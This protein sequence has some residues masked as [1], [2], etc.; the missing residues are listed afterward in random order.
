MSFTWKDT[1]ATISM[2][3]A[4]TLAI[5]L[6]AGAFESIESRWAL[7]TFALLVLGG[8]TGLITGT[9]KMMERTWSIILLYVVTV[10]ALTITVVNAFLNSQLWFMAMVIAYAVVWLEFL[11]VDLTT[12][13]PRT[14]GLPRGGAA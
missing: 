9:V 13:T 4:V 1:V 8:I 7:A 3:V 11:S 5:S 6:T 14:P 2:I 12:R 10:A